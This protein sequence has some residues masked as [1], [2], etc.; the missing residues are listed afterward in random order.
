MWHMSRVTGGKGKV[1]TRCRRIS[2]GRPRWNV[3]WANCRSRCHWTGAGWVA[4]RSPRR[5]EPERQPPAADAAAAAAAVW[6]DSG[7]SSWLFFVSQNDVAL[8][9]PPDREP[10]VHILF[11][12]II[13][14]FLPSHV[15]RA[16][17]RLLVYK[18]SARREL[19]SQF[20]PSILSSRG[21]WNEVPVSLFKVKG[22]NVFEQCYSYLFF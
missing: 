3:A 17:V 11:Y 13:I 4:G 1:L 12:F 22:C 7:A 20:L 9:P 2:W 16:P 10:L 21:F 19:T 14:F 15:S 6:W 8:Q 5:P 18:V